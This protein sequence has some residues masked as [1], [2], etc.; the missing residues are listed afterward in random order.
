[1]NKKDALKEVLAKARALS[2]IS[3][4]SDEQNAELEGHMAEAKGLRNDI[5]RDTALDEFTTHISDEVGPDKPAADAKSEVALGYDGGMR[6]RPVMTADAKGWEST[7]KAWKSGDKGAKWGFDVRYKADVDN[8][9]AE[10]GFGGGTFV[11]ATPGDHQYDGVVSPFY[12]PGI[13]EP[14]T[15]TPMV[16]DLFAQGQTNSNLIRLVK[17]TF[18]STDANAVNV[19]GHGV[20]ATAEGATYGAVKLEISP[21]D[22][23]VRDITGLLPVTEDILTDIPAMASY[24]SMRLSKFVQLAEEG[25]LVSGDATGNHLEG[26]LSLADSTVDTQGGFDIDTAVLR[27]LA[28]TYKRSFM[29]PTWV[30]MSPMVWAQYVTLRTNL[31]GGQG[32]FLSGVPTAAA[33]R[34]IWGLPITVTPVVPDDKVLVGNPAEGMIF[35]NGGMRVESST[36]YG[37]FFGEGLVAIRGKVRT[38]FAHFRPQAIGVLDL[39]S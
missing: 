1:M 39:S 15:R 24:L 18:T 28:R 17:E 8:S 11:G 33:T 10:H 9:V 30:L 3:E 29:D 2:E 12:Y 27:L 20:A 7:V 21:V 23:P 38:A 34:T 26:L 35:R 32:A 16:S 4:R 22:W 19:G 5:V 31:N 14:P 13:I 37:T 25:E 6:G 36:G